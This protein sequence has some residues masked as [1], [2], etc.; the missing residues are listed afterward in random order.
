MS[1]VWR[2]IQRS[3]KKAAKYRFTIIP[4]ELLIIGTNKWTPE[5]VLVACLHRRRRVESKVRKWERGISDPCRGL[6]VWPEQTS[7][8]LLFETTLY[9]NNVTR[10]YDDKEWIL[11]VEELTRKGKHLPIGAVNLN[12][13]LFIEN[14]PGTGAELKLKLRPLW[15]E[16]VHCSI[17]ILIYCS[18]VDEGEANIYKFKRHFIILAMNFREPVTNMIDEADTK[19]S[20]THDEIIKLRP[21][22]NQLP[23]VVENEDILAWCQRITNGYT[24]VKI[25]DFTKSFRSGLAFCALIHRYKPDLIGDFNKL[26]FSDLLCARRDNC[27]KLDAGIIATLPDRQDVLIFLSQLRSLLEGVS[28]ADTKLKDSDHRVSALFALS[29]SEAKLENLRKQR[30]HEEAIDLTN[31]PIEDDS[32]QTTLDRMKRYGSMRGQE[33]A[34]TVARMAGRTVSTHLSS[35]EE[36]ECLLKE[37]MRL[38]NEK[39]S[40]VRKSEYFNVL[41]QL[42]DVNDNIKQFSEDNRTEEDKQKTDAMM[43]ELVGLVNK[44]DQL[45]QKDEEMGER[46]RLTLEAAA[47]FSRGFEQPI[48][49]SKR[50]I[51]WIRSEIHS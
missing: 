25:T 4:Q 24:S 15:A 8:P 14:S 41:E 16:V 46:D 17:Q 5:N 10:V 30:E 35:S 12:M 37:H 18:L 3:N 1:L 26:D 36:E 19:I 44:K 29:E 31:I 28:P 39:D 2:K 45:S 34:E 38:L 48:S 13:R 43:E 22:Y 40:L 11:M 9:G 32:T 49:A 20:K 50:L 23:E 21:V 42:H 47:K 6:I 7:D 27:R 51:T 33:L